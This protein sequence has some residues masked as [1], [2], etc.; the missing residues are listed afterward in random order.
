MYGKSGDLVLVLIHSQ[1][2]L[3]IPPAVLIPTGIRCLC[4][5]KAPL[6]P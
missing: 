4:T 1:A 3:D 6:R 2:A 5:S